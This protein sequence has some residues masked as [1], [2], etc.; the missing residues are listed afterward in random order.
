MP[1]QMFPMSADLGNPPRKRRE[2]N[3]QRPSPHP[4]SRRAASPV[5]ALP[6]SCAR[7]S[8]T[9]NHLLNREPLCR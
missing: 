5:A 9:L 6:L 8:R 2:L 3:P 4:L 1:G 7:G